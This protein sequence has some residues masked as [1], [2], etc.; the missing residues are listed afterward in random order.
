MISG[1][2]R[3]DVRRVVTGH[4][5]N[6]RANIR[7]DDRIAP[8]AVARGDAKFA[9]VWTMAAAPADNND[10]TDGATRAAG[11]TLRGGSV[12]R[13][14]DLGRKHHA[15][16]LAPAQQSP[17]HRSNSIDYGIVLSGQGDCMSSDA[18]LFSGVGGRCQPQTAVYRQVCKF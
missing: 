5:A 8:V 2:G 4:G 17:V 16:D 18:G 10:D 6:G 11:L 15:Y 1:S 3:P 12:I 9:L 13:V 14:V 7:I